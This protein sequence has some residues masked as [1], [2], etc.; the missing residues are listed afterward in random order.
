MWVVWR[1]FWWEQT[2][3]RLTHI[4]WKYLNARENTTNYTDWASECTPGQ[5]QSKKRGGGQCHSH[6][7][8]KQKEKENKGRRAVVHPPLSP[9]INTLAYRVGQG[10]IRPVFSFFFT[11]P[12]GKS[13]RD[14]STVHF[15]LFISLACMSVKEMYE[16]VQA[17][18]LHS[19]TLMSWDYLLKL[20]DGLHPSF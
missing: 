20:L 7:Q 1:R 13:L 14:G 17:M 2:S 6:P 18:Q 15:P 12:M 10:C 16:K 3:F 5:C 19:E 11:P 4:I 9:N 8:K